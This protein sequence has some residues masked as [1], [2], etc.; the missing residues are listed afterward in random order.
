MF[1]WLA[2]TGQIPEKS[3]IHLISGSVEKCNELLKGL[4]NSQLSVGCM[5][6]LQI[7]LPLIERLHSGLWL[8]FQISNPG[9]MACRC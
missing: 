4:V 1:H 3:Q 8:C 6:R 2:L 5:S 7:T 9:T